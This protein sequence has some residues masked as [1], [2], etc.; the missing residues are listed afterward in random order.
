MDWT[1]IFQFVAVFL[2]SLGGAGG[3]I[4]AIA[5]WLGK[6][7][8]ERIM[9]SYKA[10]QGKDLETL[11][12]QYSIELEKYKS[13]ANILFSQLERFNAQQFSLYNDLWISLLDLKVMADALWNRASPDDLLRFSRQLK[14]T[15]KAVERGA[16]FLEEEHYTNLQGLI[17]I[18]KNF[19]F[20]KTRLIELRTRSDL[21][22][23]NIDNEQI[24][25]QIENNRPYKV[26]KSEQVAQ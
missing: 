1:Q 8:A 24:R 25:F 14:E 6:I 9:E 13:R 11:K 23:R 17:N 20:G 12:N 4:V 5:S 7:W 18:F 21:E 26:H 10:Q 22:G 2:L 3:I 16:I 15:S 19:E